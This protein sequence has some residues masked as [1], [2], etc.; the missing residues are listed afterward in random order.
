MSTVSARDPSIEVGSAKALGKRFRSWVF[1]LPLLAAALATAYAVN[2]ALETPGEV[3]RDELIAAGS[4]LERLPW[5][6]PSDVVKHGV[7]RY[8]GATY[9]VT[10]D[11]KDFPVYVTVTLHNVGHDACRDAY[12]VASRIE[13]RVVIAIDQPTPARPCSDGTAMTWRIMP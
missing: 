11:V 10:V 9:E 5:S 3:I 12:R 1:A 4:A 7:A 8:F 6:T 2:L 13:G